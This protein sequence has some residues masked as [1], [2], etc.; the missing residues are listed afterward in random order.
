[1]RNVLFVES[2]HLE[3]LAFDGDGAVPAATNT[4]YVNGRSVWHV[5]KSLP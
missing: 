2:L 3:V 5:P 1:M 4:G